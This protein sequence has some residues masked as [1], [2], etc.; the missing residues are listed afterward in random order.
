MTR[1]LLVALLVSGLA[2][3]TAL[4][5]APAPPTGPQ[6][7]TV[8]ATALVYPALADV[9]PP[10][11]RRA[12][13][14]NGLVVFLA[15]DRTL[16]LVRA[17][18]RV[19]V[20]A[21][22]DPAAEVGLAAVAAP[23]MRTGG[24]G[25]LSS[26]AL[27]LALESV[28]ASVE[29]QAG[30]DATTVSMSALTE[31]LGTALPLFAAVLTA[32]RFEAGPV[33]LARA[34]LAGAIARRNDDP[35]EVAA[36]EFAT[37]LYGPESPYARVPEVWTVDA[38]SAADA[39]AWH[40]R[41]VVPA[42]TFLAVW[43]DFDTDE[44]IE[45]LDAALGAWQTPDGFAPPETP[46]PTVRADAPAGR[47]VLLVDR[48]D[49]NQSTITLGH[50]GAVKRDSPD[51]PA[52]VV[53]NE[54]LGGGFPSRLYRTVRTDLGLA[55]GVSGA[56]TADFLAPGL[57]TAT[58]ATRSDAT[59]QATRAVLDV[60]ASLATTPPTDAELRQ[61][62]ESY[63]NAFV[64]NYDSR[65]EVLGRQLTY[66]AYGYPADFLESLR[67]GV[68]AVTSEDVSR[69]AQ[70]YLRPES[71]LVLVVGDAGAFG[72]SL[73]ALGTVERVDTAIPVVPPAG[74]AGASGEAAL[75]AVATALGGRD[76]FAAIRALRTEGETTVQQGPETVRIGTTTAIR[77]PDDARGVAVRSEQRLPAGTV[78]ILI[79]D[80]GN[81][82]L[83]PGATPADA[84]VA[85][86]APAALVAQVR[87]Q[88]FLSL[89]VLL[90]RLDGLD[91]E[92]LPSEAG[93][94]LALRPAGSGSVYRL[95]VG[96]DG[97]PTAVAT[98]QLTP[99]GT[100][101]VVVALEDYRTVS[102]AAG[103]LSLPFRYVQTVNGAAAGQTQL[104]AIEVDPVLA[105]GLFEAP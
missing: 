22:Q 36:R 19:G 72:E 101:E 57:F 34:Q 31:T 43:G 1:S 89:P 32:P 69:V 56:Y 33:A 91:A 5:T 17:T 23:A 66:A 9:A 16:P 98:T 48:D 44:M 26:D 3:C 54:V 97:R 70:T 53:M 64:F 103:P 21:F 6:I 93:T 7:A 78:T 30:D 49:V 73:D 84:P 71:A 102:T 63:L 59:V 13:L 74:S 94:V 95:S 68:E 86:D 104:S 85:Q 82:V 51:F 39:R 11:V 105:G 15:E 10:A 83:T 27:N 62:K 52:L 8:D 50:I 42:N 29:A 65:A 35:G 90:A 20:G 18:A 28:G 92:T 46:Q 81:R 60:A 37:G 77:L 25:D 80:T 96:A 88:L 99:Q 38:V 41:H 87:A 45:R 67:R 4:G 75:A 76:A 100:A 24:A 14:S 47:R 55:Y 58:T 12:E 40:A 79:G 61:A 2:G